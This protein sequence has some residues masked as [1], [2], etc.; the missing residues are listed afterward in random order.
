MNDARELVRGVKPALLMVLVQVVY[1]S[2]NVLYKFAIN[3]GMSTRVVTAYRLIFA[4]PF[5]I[6]LA[7]IFERYN[8]FLLLIGK[9]I[10]CS[11][12][13]ASNDNS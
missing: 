13:H 10:S 6:F 3:D 2:V 11:M 9:I 5:T 4:T 1:A 8:I 7:L 12:T